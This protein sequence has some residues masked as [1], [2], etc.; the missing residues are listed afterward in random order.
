MN[1]LQQT[2]DGANGKIRLSVGGYELVALIDSGAPV[3]TIPGEQWKWMKESAVC[4]KVLIENKE[5]IFA[6][7]SISPLEI[8]A[9]FLATTSVVGFDKPHIPNV[10]WH[11]IKGAGQALISKETAE[12]LKILKVGI[13]VKALETKSMKE[14]KANLKPKQFPKIPFY[15][16]K[17]KINKEVPPVRIARVRIPAPL[18]EAVTERLDEMQALGIIEDAPYDTEWISPMEIVI[19]G[20][21][22]FRI[23][24][25]MRRPNEAIQRAHHPLPEVQQVLEKIQ[26]AKFFTKLDLTSAFFPHGAAQRFKKYYLIHDA[27][28]PK[29]I[30]ENGIR[31][32]HSSRSISTRNGEYLQKV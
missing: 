20:K 8:E 12:Q 15:Q 24:L 19:K 21:D 9:T 30:Y 13:E 27:Q 25:D 11:V 31:S 32:K 4:S 14:T 23:V 17:F 16:L 5:R 22:D 29:E 6:Y 7:A 10:Q 2:L 3:N 18:R 1:I 28:R 26:G